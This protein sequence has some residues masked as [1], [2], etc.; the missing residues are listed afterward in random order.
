MAKKTKSVEEKL[1]ELYDL[2]LIDSNI[3]QIKIMKGALPIEVS[4]LEDEIT[5]LE[6]RLQ[7]LN[8]QVEEIDDK[9]AKHKENIK[10]SETL[11]ERYNKQLDEVKNNREFEALT[12]EIELQSLEIQL[13]EKRIKEAQLEKEN[14]IEVKNSTSERFEQKQKDLVQKKEELEQIITKTDK[15]EKKLLSKSEKQRELIEERLLKAYDKT[16]NA[17]R[18]G[19]A[20]VTHRRGSCGGC[21][22]R[23]PPQLQIE[24][25]MKKEILACEHCGRVL[26]DH[27]IAGI[28]EEETA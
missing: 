5:G 17:Y 14:K 20:V 11:I 8:S 27:E 15:E 23:I 3:D 24:I 12:K 13:S 25:G 7:K 9:I 21:F 10:T 19:L 26:V 28:V 6:T 4:D 1:Q 18:N 22:N 16:R 2:Q